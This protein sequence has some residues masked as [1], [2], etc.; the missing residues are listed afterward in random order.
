MAILLFLSWL[1]G[2]LGL[3][4]LSAVLIIT[5]IFVSVT[6]PLLTNP[7]DASLTPIFG[8][9]TL[10]TI[11]AGALLP[12]AAA[13]ITGALSCLDILLIAYISLQPA[14][15]NPGGQLHMTTLNILSIAVMVPIVI[16]I[17]VALIVYIIMRNLL[18]ALHRAER[19]EEIVALQSEI[20]AHERARLQAQEQLEE[21]FRQIAEAHARIANGDYSARVALSEGH[22]LGSVA[23]SLNNLIQRL[24]RWRNDASELAQTRQAAESIAKQLHQIIQA[25]Q[26]RSLPATNTLLDPIILEINRIVSPVP[27]RPPAPSGSPVRNQSTH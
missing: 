21:G 27:P 13:L 25:R 10:G 9:F 5:Y 11:L 24:Q 4:R 12:P 22:V 17:I 7:L 20:S 6:G 2:R 1:C 15:Y 8:V 26:P 19:A 18:T 14:Q 23:M 16:Q 3:Q